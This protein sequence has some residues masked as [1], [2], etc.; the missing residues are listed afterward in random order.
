VADVERLVAQSL[1]T[2]FDV[3][4]RE[5]AEVSEER[6]A[7]AG[8]NA[9]VEAQ[10]PPISIPEP[11]PVG[12]AWEEWAEWRS[13]YKALVEVSKESLKAVAKREGQKAWRVFIGDAQTTRRRAVQEGDLGGFAR[14]VFPQDGKPVAYA[15]GLLT[16]GE[17]SRLPA[18]VEERLLAADKAKEPTIS[19]NRWITSEYFPPFLERWV[20]TLGHP[21]ARLRVERAQPG[22]EMLLASAFSGTPVETLEEAQ[23]PDR[24]RWG[25][26]VAWEGIFGL[27][28][29]E[30]RKTLL[31]MQPS[32]APG[33]SG[34]KM[35]ALQ[36]FPVWVQEWAVALLEAI[37]IISLVP[38][39][40]KDHEVVHLLKS[41]G[42]LREITLFEEI[43]KAAD[44]LVLARLERVRLAAPA[45]SVLSRLNIA[46]EA[47]LDADIMVDLDEAVW[48]DA[49][50]QDKS[51]VDLTLDYWSY[52]PRCQPL[53]TDASLEARGYPEA[54][55]DWFAE[56]DAEQVVRFRTPWGSTIGILRLI[57]YAQGLQ[58]T[59]W[60]SKLP[61]DPLLR[62][63]EEKGA[64]YQLGPR[65]RDADPVEA[66]GKAY[67]DDGRFWS[68]GWEGLVRNCAVISFAAPRLGIGVKPT[69]VYARGNRRAGAPPQEGIWMESWDE[70]AGELRRD[71][72]PVVPT[73]EPKEVLGVPKPREGPAGH[74]GR[75][76]MAGVAAKLGQMCAKQ[77]AWD[78][79]RAAVTMGPA[80]LLQYAPIHART[81]HG[82]ARG[83]DGSIARAARK[84]VRDPASITPYG[85]FTEEGAG[86][87]GIASIAVERA[88]AVARGLL[89]ALL[90]SGP[91]GEA[92]RAV[93]ETQVA[94]PPETEGQEELSAFTWAEWF[95][96]GYGLY[97]RDAREKTFGRFLD[98]L[99]EA[100]Q[101]SRQSFHRPYDGMLIAKK[102]FSLGAN[103]PRTH[104]A[105][106]A[107]HGRRDPGRPPRPRT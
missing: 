99:S 59:A 14:R 11:P 28:T 74:Y 101:H 3:S 63:L 20:D 72:V 29:E 9:A 39:A 82:Q 36:Y 1:N 32:K 70:A 57:G 91:D 16:S 45:G 25:H 22:Q 7:A 50:I 10:A 51:L 81:E 46:Y 106:H 33:P 78:E 13:R 77:L 94:H 35:A 76:V 49:T 4:A 31:R 21:R 86:G 90:R 83:Q 8:A 97:L 5:G 71:R 41:D 105:R 54:V 26:G 34:F 55:G 18:T 104:R 103:P 68:P 65:V 100:D 85:V 89:A 107:P 52:F 6:S 24:R 79:V 69:K 27:I 58:S 42:G 48:A 102:C 62:W 80:S 56:L 61:Q 75:K 17:T 64:A 66:V 38:R 95:L 47:G 92:V 2:D 73:S 15:P 60:R 93:W 84:S 23:H 37:I 53:I 40:V 67:S 30:E 87:L 96:A 43:L 88:G 19:V 12:A 98:I 44:G